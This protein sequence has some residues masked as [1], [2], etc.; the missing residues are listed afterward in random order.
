MSSKRKQDTS[1]YGKAEALTTFGL[2][3]TTA[4]DGPVGAPLAGAGV[5]GGSGAMFDAIAERY[6][7][8]NRLM[9][10]GI[11]QRWR[12]L[13]IDALE[14]PAGAKILD[15]ATGTGD[16]AI[17]AA[18]RIEGCTVVGIDASVGMLAVGIG[19]VKAAGLIKRIDLRHGDACQLEVPDHFV[20]G[21][22]MGFGIRNVQNRAKALREIARVLKPGARVVILEATEPS[23]WLGLGAKFHMHVVVPRVGALL[24]K[25]PQYRYL[26]QSVAAFPVPKRFAEIM[27]SSGLRVIEIR[28][29]LFGVA[30]LWIAVP[31]GD[32][33]PQPPQA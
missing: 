1:K 29:L 16:L 21:V 20:D 27:E 28:R 31:S 26:Q 17:L 8:I 25:A 4:S 18:R 33:S 11:D 32:D 23:G 7:F 9:T 12:R 2:P 13:A 30:H 24:A 10:F 5:V 15:L 14:A 6:D 22:T 3:A 19:K